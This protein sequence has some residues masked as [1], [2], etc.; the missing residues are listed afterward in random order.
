MPPV[1]A[2]SVCFI[3]RAILS[4]LSQIKLRVHF[5]ENP[6]YKVLTIWALNI[7]SIILQLV[8]TF[9]NI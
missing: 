7:F 3:T 1:D 8:E 6:I 2:W 5:F 9:Q 4:N